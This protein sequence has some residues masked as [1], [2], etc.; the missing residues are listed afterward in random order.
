M[1][2]KRTDKLAVG[3]VVETLPAN[4]EGSLMTARGVGKWRT[5]ERIE[6]TRSHF[7]IDFTDRFFAFSN[8]TAPWTVRED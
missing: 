2:T 3:D 6:K 4:T 8:R 1:S 7:I 5:I